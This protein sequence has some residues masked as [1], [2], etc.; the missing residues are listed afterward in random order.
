MVLVHLAEMKCRY[1][2]LEWVKTYKAKI[3]TLRGTIAADFDPFHCELLNVSSQAEVTDEAVAKELATKYGT[4]IATQVAP[5]ADGLSFA[6]RRL[7]R[8]GIILYGAKVTFA[9]I[10]GIGLAGLLTDLYVVSSTLF[11][12]FA[13]GKKLGLGDALVTLISTGSAICGCLRWV[14]S[15]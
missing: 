3:S 11:L 15:A 1:S 5:A 7:L 8:A 6:K 4:A 14:L 12:G 9:K 2:A 10:L 13:L